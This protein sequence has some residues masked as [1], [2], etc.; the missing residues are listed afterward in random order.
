MFRRRSTMVLILLAVVST[1]AA[2]TFTTWTT[3]ACSLE[4]EAAATIEGRVVDAQRGVVPGAK[5]MLS[6]NGRVLFTVITGTDGRYLIP[7]VASGT[8]DLR[9]EML[10]FRAAVQQVTV[11]PD[12]S[13]VQVPD[14]VLVV[15][16]SNEAVSPADSSRAGGRG[17]TGRGGAGSGGGNL[18]GAAPAAMPAPTS[19]VD[20]ITSV[21]AGQASAAGVWRAGRSFEADW[22]SAPAGRGEGYARVP[23]HRF[24]RTQDEPLSTFGADVDTASFANVRRFLRNG[25]LPP[26]EAVRVEEFVN[27]FRFDYAAPRAGHPIGVTTEVA[28]C[29][30]EPRHKLVLI[31]ARAG[32]V[33]SREIAGRN[34]VLLVD[35]SGSM[36]PDDRLPLLR[37]AFSIFVNHLQP[38]D[39]LAIVTYAGSSGVALP[40][41]LVRERGRILDVIAGLGAGGS[42]NGAGGITAAYQL[43]R[44]SFI[45]GGINRVILAT[46]GD[47]NV[48]VT[49][50]Q[51]LLR[52]IEREKESGVF[53]SVLGVGT[54]NLQDATMELLADRGNGT[55]AYL[56]SLDEARRV[57]VNEMSSTL[58]TVAK[59]VKFQ[60]E[61]NPSEVAA[62]RQIGYENRALAHQ[63]FNDDR[64]D[65]GE[66]GAGHTVTVL[67]EIV[68]VGVEMPADGGDDPRVRPAIDPLRYQ[69][70]SETRPRLAPAPVAVRRGEWLTVK[71]RYQPPDGST[72]RLLVEPLQ[73]QAPARLVHLPFAAAVAEYGQLLGDRRAPT[74]RWDRLIRRLES[75]TVTQSRRTDVDQLMA[76]AAAARDLTRVR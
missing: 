52:L 49:D 30:W 46:D 16:L 69:P 3:C 42:T 26:V 13:S 63:D 33:G 72:S 54:G 44:Q 45:E 37:S 75:M 43:A 15:G 40:P 11:G 71:V 9:V 24:R 48:G 19:V 38:T 12:A 59:D 2:L 4:A 1:A 10:G 64:K 6:A 47:F 74:E 17:G 36:A 73:V 60:V 21:Q 58:E 67:Y 61:F 27:Y 39:R 8:Y 29:P 57:L 7:N 56:D 35:V 55:Y 5:V 51:G 50:P 34:I 68:P 32:S 20:G 31:G 66:M 18:P 28:D 23:A 14:V 53:L 22:P 76:L 41:T 70:E 25:Q 62:W 65:G